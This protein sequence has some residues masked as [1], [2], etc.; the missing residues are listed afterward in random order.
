[1][2]TNNLTFYTVVLTANVCYLSIFYM[3]TALLF[4][5]YNYS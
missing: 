2:L 4:E 3:A 5:L 1:L